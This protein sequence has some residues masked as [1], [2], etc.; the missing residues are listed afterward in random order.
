[1]AHDAESHLARL[2]EDD[3]LARLSERGFDW[4]ALDRNVCAAAAF[5]RRWREA[6]GLVALLGGASSGKSTLFNSLLGREVSRISAHAHET[7]GP[8]AAV[9]QV[10]SQRFD[11]WRRD[12]AIF[13]GLET[14]VLGDD[15]STTGRVGTLCLHRHDVAPLADVV[16]VDMPDVTSKMA[17]DEGSI[18]RTLLPWFD[19]L[20]IVVDEERWFDAA[21]FDETVE[22]ARNLGPRFW[23]VFNRTEDAGALA[24]LDRQRLTDHAESR[25]AAGFCVS[26]FRPGSG[27]RPVADETSRRIVTWIADTDAVG[28][29]L[30]LERHL[31][32]RCSEIVRVNV[33]RGEHFNQLRQAA[34]NEL[35]ALSAETSL[36]IDLLTDDERKLLGV[37]RQVFPLYDAVQSARRWLGRFGRKWGGDAE[38]EFDKRDER[39]AGVLRHNLEHRV[40]HAT[41]RIDQ[42]VGDSPYLGNAAAT[43]KARWTIPPFDEQEWARRIRRHLEAWK[44]ETTTRARRSDV[45][46]LSLGVPLLLADL[47]FLGGAGVTLSW[48]VVWVAGFLGGKS[49]ASFLQ[50]SPAFKEYQTTVKAYQTYL[51]EAL[52]E[53]WDAN[54]ATMPRRHLRMT[55]PVLESIMYW[56]TPGER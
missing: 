14:A 42:L 2:A 29:G 18:T 9:S 52:T 12:A 26:S 28:R 10:W 20:I 4:T 22:F 16:L 53:Q 46:S 24:P 17:A 49:L 44:S 36:S 40:E 6:P 51:R 55:D 34:N 33:A 37:G 3:S 30:D 48:A 13:P 15:E 8:V 25:H 39:L 50:R 7:R 41:N 35:A 45:A 5:K 23:V 1:M 56:S 43:W 54:L 11:A 19:G 32:R 21:V 38:I 31:Q 47:L 27:Y